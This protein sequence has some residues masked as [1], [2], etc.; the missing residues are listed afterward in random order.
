LS[1][2]ILRIEIM[3]RLG[4]ITAELSPE[5]D[6]ALKMAQRFG[7]EAVEVHT[8]WGTNVEELDPGD[9]TRFRELLTRSGLEAC[10][11]ASTVFLRCGLEGEEALEGSL[12]YQGIA[13]SYQDHLEA[14][15]RALD[16]ANEVGAPL[17]RI[18]GFWKGGPTTEAVYERIAE[19]L[20]EALRMARAAGLRLAVE[21]CP[22]TYLGWGSRT[23]RLVELVNSDRLGVLWDPAGAVRAGETR[24]LEAYPQLRPWLAHVHAKDLLLDPA[25]EG[26]RAYVPVGQGEIDWRGI[27]ARLARDGYT[28]VI[29]LETHHLGPDGS[30]ETAAEA[31]WQGLR[32]LVRKLETPGESRR[33]TA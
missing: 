2:A 21:T 5:V 33:P 27:L 17:V 3:F 28:G 22:H 32:D 6:R 18:F 12:G 15:G 1:Y 20:S 25:L 8:L 13:G 14:L 7:L 29:S 4:A 19:R 9:W 11:L 16:R 31:S 24:Y 10:C 23:A 30:K 26:G